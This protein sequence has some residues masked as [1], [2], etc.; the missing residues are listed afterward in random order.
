MIRKLPSPSDFAD[1]L[2]RYTPESAITELKDSWELSPD[3]FSSQ[4]ITEIF[5]ELQRGVQGLPLLPCNMPDY[6]EQEEEYDN[7]LF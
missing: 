5:L 7:I 1:L 4:D 3:G 2:R 6:D